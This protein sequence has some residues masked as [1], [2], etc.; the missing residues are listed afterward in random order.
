MCVGV[1]GKPP[2]L[3]KPKGELE[4]EHQFWGWMAGFCWANTIIRFH[5]CPN[6]LWRLCVFVLL[7]GPLQRQPITRKFLEKGGLA[8]GP[9]L[10]QPG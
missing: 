3:A 6:L 4:V 1:S 5:T 10:G 9:G 2:C 7:R 8:G